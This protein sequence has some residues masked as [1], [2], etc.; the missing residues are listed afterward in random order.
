MFF[1]WDFGDFVI[2][3]AV[4]VIDGYAN[5]DILR[6]I[7]SEAVRKAVLFPIFRDFRQIRPI[8]QPDKVIFSL[9]IVK[10][11]YIR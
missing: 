7:D 2:E 3:R 10:K 11:Q 8:A 6:D 9:Y 4:L 1:Y 5:F